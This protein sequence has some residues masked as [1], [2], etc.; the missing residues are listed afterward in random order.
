MSLFP[1]VCVADGADSRDAKTDRVGCPPGMHF[2]ARAPGER[3][4]GMIAS[5]SSSPKGIAS[6]FFTSVDLPLAAEFP[7]AWAKDGALDPSGV[8]LGLEARRAQMLR[9]TFRFAI[10]TPSR[11]GSRRIDYLPTRR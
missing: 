3:A 8:P 5:S 4:R 2:E 11:I 1:G 9:H 6:H 7:D 10:A